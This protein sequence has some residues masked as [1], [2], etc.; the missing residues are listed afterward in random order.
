MMS[1]LIFGLFGHR[2][3]RALAGDVLN[4]SRSTTAGPAVDWCAYDPLGREERG[5][6]LATDFLSKFYYAKFALRYGE[7]LGEE[8]S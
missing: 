6:A 5:T 4:I 2:P 1:L 8:G 7:G 3:E